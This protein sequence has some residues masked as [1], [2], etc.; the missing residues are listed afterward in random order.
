MDTFAAIDLRRTTKNFDPDSR[1]IK[2]EETTLLAAKALGFDSCP[3]IDCDIEKVAAL[4]NLSK[5]YVMGP[6]LAVGKKQKIPG[7]NLSNDPKVR[8]HGNSF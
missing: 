2:E 3:L 8:C 6:M 1:L 4:I 7:R 5:D